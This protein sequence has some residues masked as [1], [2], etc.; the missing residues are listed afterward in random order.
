MLCAKAERTGEMAFCE[1]N[2]RIA[3]LQDDWMLS[4]VQKIYFSV[5]TAALTSPHNY[6]IMIK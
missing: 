2:E 4:V 6:V 1:T 3:G 5:F